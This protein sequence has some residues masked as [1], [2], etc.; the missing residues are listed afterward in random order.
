MKKK[1]LKNICI[2]IVFLFGLAFIAKFGGPPILKLYIESGVGNCQ[3]IP[4]LCMTPA[5][6]TIKPI[7]NKEYAQELIPYQFPKMAIS[8]PKGFA[9]VQETIK[10]VYYK[11]SGRPQ[12]GPVIY[13]LYK[14]PGFFVNLFPQSKGRGIKDNYEFIKQ[15]MYAKP[16]DIKN[17]NDAFFVI[18]KGIFIP[19]LGEQNN[20]KMIK[21]NFADKKGFINYNLSKPD[22][23]F[24]CNVVNNED[25]YFKIYIKDKAA[26]LDLDKVFVIISTL[27][28]LK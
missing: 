15:T 17:I 19:D 10:K 3:K 4:I 21:F 27:S 8:I 12:G 2:A 24:D 13:A 16:A 18:M 26:N 22:S 5:E 6:E 20:V 23:Y 11:R 1:V 28:R 9:I 14:E 7:I 25:T